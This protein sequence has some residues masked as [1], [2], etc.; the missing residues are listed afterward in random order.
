MNLLKR[1]LDKAEILDAAMTA[2]SDNKSSQT[3]FWH[4]HSFDPSM[5]IIEFRESFKETCK[6]SPNEVLCKTLDTKNVFINEEISE[7]PKRS[8]NDRI[9]YFNKPYRYILPGHF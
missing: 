4:K 7:K 1:S 5:D 8:G 2:V 9:H 3:S 6:K